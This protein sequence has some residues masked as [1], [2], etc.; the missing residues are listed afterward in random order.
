MATD[1]HLFSAAHLAIAGC[2]PASAAA[3]ATWSRSSPGRKLWTRRTLGALLA[4]NE[5]VWYSFRLRHEGFRFPEGLPIN[6]CDVTL[7]LTVVSL[8]TL[9]QRVFEFAYLTGAAGAGMAI[10][11][12]DLWAPMWSYPTMY[13]FA[14]HGGVVAGQLYVI[15]S[16]QVRPHPG[17]VWRVLAMVNGYAL[18]VGLF[19]LFFHTNYMYL[20][21][22]PEG[23]SVLDFLGP[24]PV[25]LLGGELVAIVLFWLL[26][27]P[28]RPR[29][30][31]PAAPAA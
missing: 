2:V 1:F 27:L 21:E 28:F 20:C 16:G 24:W 3:L 19:N 17:C 30:S 5:L 22:K 26:Y 25:Y 14:A 23:A 8:L 7:W 9:R 4:A 15:W 10:L 12:P 29:S 31:Q 6:L 11:T 18:A 13:F